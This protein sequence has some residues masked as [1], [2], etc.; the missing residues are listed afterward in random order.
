MILMSSRSWRPLAVALSVS[1]FVAPAQQ[2]SVTVSP[3][4]LGGQKAIVPLL[5]SNG[6]TEKVESARAVIFLLDGEGK[7]VGQASHWIIGGD[8]NHPPLAVGGTNTYHFVIPTAGKAFVTNR[9][10]VTHVKLAN[11]KTA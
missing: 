8:T 10:S 5:L 6:L 11:G 1:A 9:L 2:L 4:K 3:T 7:V